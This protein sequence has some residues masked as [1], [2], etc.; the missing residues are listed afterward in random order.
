M[1]MKYFSIPF[2]SI[3]F[4]LFS[5]IFSRD[6]KKDYHESYEVRSGDIL[7]LS[8]GDGDVTLSSWNKDIVDIE[9]YFSANVFGLGTD[10]YD[11]DIQ[12]KQHGNEI[13]VL[14]KFKSNHHFGIRGIKI[15]RYE[16]I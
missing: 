11:F 12:F 10:E 9:V 5:L 6:I 1:N 8:H 3:L 16:Y 13:E 4:L 15:N 2:Y 7:Y 14:E